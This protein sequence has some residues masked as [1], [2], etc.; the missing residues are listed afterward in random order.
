MPTFRPS[1]PL[2]SR[3]ASIEVVESAGGEITVVPA[4]AAVLGVQYRGRVRAGA[5][6]LS[7]AG[8]TG[9][10][11]GPRRY[12]YEPG[13]GT[14]LVR[15]TP[16]GAACLG[17]P[18]WQLSGQSIALDAI[19]PSARVGELAQRL[20]DAPGPRARV[21]AVEQLLLT[22]P[23]AQD[24]LVAH[25]M[26]RLS[27]A[28]QSVARLAS[29][30]GLSERQLERRFLQVV[31]ITPKRFATL[32]RFE[33]T[34]ALAGSTPS[35]TQLALEAGYYDQSH[36][37]REFRGYAGIAPGAFLSGRIGM[38]DS[39]NRALAGAATVAARGHHDERKR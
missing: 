9:I 20:A 25:A 31:G 33:R 22:L 16:Q 36:F 11:S 7:T 17:V 27:G 29:E 23:F 38:S 8:V 12:S 6:L 34:L 21:D 10:Q 35:L 24:R 39:S 30:L 14:I 1:P 28:A 32:R 18:A 3:V 37:I 4:S 19:L 5:E 26:E 13:T 15:F 2:R